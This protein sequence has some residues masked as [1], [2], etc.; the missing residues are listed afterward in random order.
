MH[1]IDSPGS[2]A[3]AWVDKNAQTGVPGTQFVATWMN[4]LQNELV[5][6][7]EATGIVLAKGTAT[8]LRDAVRRY[9][10]GF[11]T[12]VVFA[13]SPKSLTAANAGLVIVDASGGNITI[14]LPA[15]NALAAL[16]FRFIRSDGS[17]NTVTINRAGADTF[18]HGTGSPTAI[19]LTTRYRARDVIS[20][21]VSVWRVV[22]EHHPRSPRW[23]EKLV[24]K[25]NTTTPNSKLDITADLL[26]V[27]GV[28]FSS[29]SLTVDI[30]AAGANGLDA[31]AE[32]AS[33]WYHLWAIADVRD[34]E[35]PVIASLLST[36]STAPTLPANYT[37][38]QYI[39]AI[40]ND[41]SS[42]FIVIRQNNDRVSRAPISVLSGGTATVETA[43][44]LVSAL[45]VTAR[46]AYGLAGIS[47]AISLLVLIPE[48][49]ASQAKFGGVNIRNETTG[50]QEVPWWLPM[51][52]TQTMYYLIEGAGGSG[53]I[54]ICGWEY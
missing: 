18:G 45:P 48:S 50:N 40:Y 17:A 19:K 37:L 14:N 16:A 29:V 47:A 13:D 10:G 46:S 4:E 12:T 22:T 20:D 2:S 28:R 25:N 36:S 35:T 30:A 9:A 15:A 54:L 38:K 39:G 7:I 21:G 41:A 49:V 31:G 51:H 43:V 1:K 52:V 5:N 8:Q 32:A 34:P 44:S 24:V 11:V 53:A 33:T 3:G 42:N 6:L 26:D 23:F 27:E